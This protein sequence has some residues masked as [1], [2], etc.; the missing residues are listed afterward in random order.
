M[1]WER[2]WSRI[3]AIVGGYFERRRA[4]EKEK[5]S[6]GLTIVWT[7]SWSP[8]LH[9][10]ARSY[11]NSPDSLDLQPAKHIANYQEYASIPKVLYNVKSYYSYTKVVLV[12]YRILIILWESVKRKTYI[13]KL[14]T[15]VQSIL[16]S[17]DLLLIPWPSISFLRLFLSLYLIFGQILL[18]AHMDESEILKNETTK[19]KER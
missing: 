11:C 1:L 19:R 12:T 5:R 14:D 2:D 18:I 6:K 10:A 7:S 16:C 4:Q 13:T 15:T 8:E 3:I 9:I 17:S